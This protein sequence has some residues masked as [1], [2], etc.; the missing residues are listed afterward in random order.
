M[1]LESLEEKLSSIINENTIIVCVGNPFRRDDAAG[2]I[3][4]RTLEK[5]VGGNKVIVCEHGVENC[6]QNIMEQ[7]PRNILVVDAAEFEGKP[8]DV[9]LASAL[10]CDLSAK[11]LSTHK[12]PLN[13]I[14]E[15]LTRECGVENVWLLG[16]KPSAVDFGVGVSKTVLETCKALAE[17]LA[18]ILK[19]R[20]EKQSKEQGER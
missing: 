13:L 4:C 12:I 2:L 17:I 20:E 14:A 11:P 9:V 1:A 7:K 19:A 3:V 15:Y 10:E 5:L 6:L 18:G 8:G 16:I